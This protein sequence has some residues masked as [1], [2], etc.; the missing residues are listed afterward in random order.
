MQE[1]YEALIHKLKEEIKDVAAEA[2]QEQSNY[3]ESETILMNFIYK[4][5]GY[6]ALLALAK[7][8]DVKLGK[9]INYEDYVECTYEE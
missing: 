1:A 2:E 6:Q 7:E 9:G 4:N 8:I 3:M 5:H